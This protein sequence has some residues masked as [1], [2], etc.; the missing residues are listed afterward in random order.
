MGSKNIV[1][2]INSPL[3]AMA[4]SVKEYK[5][6]Q[7]NI[8]LEKVDKNGAIIDYEE[9]SRL[10]IGNHK[11][12]NLIASYA[13]PPPFSVDITENNQ[14]IKLVKKIKYC[15]AVKK[16]VRY[17]VSFEY[18][19]FI[20]SSYLECAPREQI[21]YIDHGFG[22]PAR[23]LLKTD[24]TNLKL[25]MLKKILKALMGLP[26]QKNANE[27]YFAL[28]KFIG[29]SCIHIDLSQY[30]V[31]KRLRSQFSMLEIKTSDLQ[32]TLVL[33]SDQWEGFD[34]EGYDI[35]KM[36]SS[37][38]SMV[39][40][41]CSKNEIIL[42]KGHPSQCLSN[43]HNV[44]SAVAVLL[45]KSG[46]KV[47]NLDECVSEEIRCKLPAE[48]F[49]NFIKIKR[50]VFEA[51]A[52]PLAFLHKQS[53]GAVMECE[54]FSNIRSSNEKEVTEDLVGLNKHLVHPFVLS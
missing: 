15:L 1:Y 36:I 14:L 8:I 9:I 25:L 10:I 3:V 54:L 33:V 11:K 41:N 48:I 4:C 43:N 45:K 37:N 35:G 17:D 2:V 44:I 13:L 51:S 40:K 5:S 32:K 39:E 24:T 21:K 18:I 53:I 38:V 19:G 31:P 27:H 16:K 12:I 49:L 29:D 28:A 50:V 23:R 42:L 20:T 26:P 6:N 52:T 7:V 46:F 34:N 47:Y 30:R 22:E